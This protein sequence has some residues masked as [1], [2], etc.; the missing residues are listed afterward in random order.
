MEDIIKKVLYTGVGIAT[1]T[2]EKLQETVDEWVG[3]GKVSEEEGKK[4]VDDFWVKVDNRKNEIEEK[5][6]EMFEN[7]ANKVNIPTIPTREELDELVKRVEA[8]EAQAGTTVSE[9]VKAAV[10]E[11]AKEVKKT[12]RKTTRKSTKKTKTD[13]DGTTK[14]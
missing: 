3:K 9:E 10:K 6:K 14:K 12:A 7:A 2:A 4:I 13:V 8:L 1:V 11:T 5:V